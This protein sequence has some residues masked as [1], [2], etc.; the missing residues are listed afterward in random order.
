MRVKEAIELLENEYRCADTHD[1][2]EH[3][4]MGIKALQK[5]L[6]LSLTEVYPYNLARAI[7]QDD[8][9][10]MELSVNGI[11]QAL[12]TLTERERRVIE[13]RAKGRLTLEQVGKL[14]N[15]TRERIRQIEAKALRKL[16]HP[17][18]IAKMRAY[19]YQDVMRHSEEYNQLLQK[20]HELEKI[21]RMYAKK[22]INEGEMQELA[23]KADVS[24]IP[25]EE[26]DLSVRSYNCLKRKG[27]NCIG[28]L[29]ELT[30]ADLQ[31]VRNLGRK[32]MEEILQKLKERGLELKEGME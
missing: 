12:S 13:H 6:Q 21:I 5:S 23:E 8:E 29:L 25:I 26:L 30:L 9:K 24:Q 22:K 11:E 7:L 15:V 20:V 31:I 18:R 10:A 19:S 16:R 1:D 4:L 14:E 17:S 2:G 28:D 3:Y 27:I 32:S